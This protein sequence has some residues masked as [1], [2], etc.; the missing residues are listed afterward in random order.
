MQ[1][2]LVLREAFKGLGRNLTMTVAMVITTAISVALVVV[3]R[4][5][6]QHDQRHQGDLL[7]ARG[8]HGSAQ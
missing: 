3:K 5:G 1:L 7:G 2:G 6:D 8:S 4:A